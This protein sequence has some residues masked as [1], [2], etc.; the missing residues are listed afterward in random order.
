M[1]APINQSAVSRMLNARSIAIVGVSS[2]PTSNARTILGHLQ[3]AHYSGRIFLVG[4]SG[5]EIDGIP[6]LSSVDELPV[7]VDVAL[8]TVRSAAVRE[9]IGA[10]VR[11]RVGAAVLYASGFAELGETGRSEQAEVARIAREGGVHLLG[12]NCI[13]YTN[14]VEPLT[15]VFL[16]D[17]PVVALEPGVDDALAIVTQS[18]GLL[19]L[20]HTGLTARGLKVSYRITTGNEAGITLSDVLAFLADDPVTSGA[21]VYA[22]DIRDPQS[23]LSAVRTLRARGK[24]VTLL[25]SGRSDQAREAAAS[26]TGA[27][28]ADYALMKTMA[29]R[30]GAC[31]VESLEELLDVTEILAR[32]PTPQA[33]DIAVTTTSGAFCA[34]AIDT[35]SDL[36]SPVTALSQKTTRFLSGRMPAYISPSNPLDL[37]TAP[38]TD[39]ALFHDCVAALLA[40][41]GFGSVAVAAPFVDPQQNREMLVQV[42][43]AAL[44]QAK[45][46]VISMFADLQPVPDELRH[47]AAEHGMVLSTSP[48]RTLRAL[49]T[50]SRY[51]KALARPVVPLSGVE[52]PRRAVESGPL[53]EWEGKQLLADIGISIPQGALARSAEEAIAIGERIGYPVVAKAQSRE[54]QHKTES[55]GLVLGIADSNA[56]GTAFADLERRLPGL[57][58]I[59]VESMAAGGIELMVGATRHPLWGPVVLVGL[60]GV[61]VEAL[62]DVRMLPAD[63]NTADIIE[64]LQQLRSAKLLGRFRGSEPV[65]LDAVAEI[66][67]KVGQ[68][69]RTHPEIAELDINPVVARPDSVTALDALIV[70]EAAQSPV[71]E[72]ESVQ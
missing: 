5:G 72:L 58:G 66:V 14:Y 11:R 46:V 48:E 19:G 56:L 68:F 49:A 57:D 52:R 70:F 29:T 34:V 31:V 18:G 53:A 33:G 47:Y 63:L 10:C 60:G 28:S 44:G 65:D 62:G 50:V 12:P 69:M 67:S 55:G 6:V 22:E 59:L 9:V 15:T 23:F 36:N 24:T 27:L 38:V 3:N 71:H 61:W 1:P 43:R 45:P 20:I 35:L 51:G 30:A 7:D 41:D 42:T 40:D 26:H 16:P 25:H 32:F 64:E 54:L 13:G 17:A 2:A 4:R 8:L 21:V 37:G 39:P